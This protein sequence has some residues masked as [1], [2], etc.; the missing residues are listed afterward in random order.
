MDV[1]QVIEITEGIVEIMRTIE[2]VRNQGRGP[3]FHAKFSARIRRGFRRSWLTGRSK[4]FM[5][6]ATGRL[7]FC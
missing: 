1:S 6:E 7:N 4:G 2:V 3:R 5:L